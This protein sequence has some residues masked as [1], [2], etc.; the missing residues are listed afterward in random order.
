MIKGN[1]SKN[2]KKVLKRL[3]SVLLH[4]WVDDWNAETWKKVV[5]SKPK[6]QLVQFWG[7]V[8]CLNASMD[9]K[10][11]SLFFLFPGVDC[12]NRVF[13]IS[14]TFC[15]D[16]VRNAIS[17]GIGAEWVWSAIVPS[18]G[19]DI[20]PLASLEAI[21]KKIIIIII[22]T[23]SDHQENQHHQQKISLP[24]TPVIF[25]GSNTIIWY[26]VWYGDETRAGN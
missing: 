5:E 13:K 21:T 24:V 9:L 17:Q 6:Q 2:L 18:L 7:T 22:I 23:S 11:F 1:G 20:A 16:I 10:I 15:A 19:A 12:W 4:F 25:N 8:L 26:M 3:N 14:L